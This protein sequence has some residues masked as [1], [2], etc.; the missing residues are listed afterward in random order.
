MA[1]A[2]LIVMYPR[3]KNIGEFESVYHNEHVP[4]A[5]SKLRGKTKIVA[6][7]VVGTPQMTAAF[8]RFAEIHF[9]SMRMLEAC[10]AS[11]EGQEVL[12]HATA[13]SSGG[14]P[15]LLVAEEETFNF[16][17]MTGRPQESLMPGEQGGDA[18]RLVLDIAKALV[19]EL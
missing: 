5:I 9:P 8:H 10:A 6:T 13:I 1:G 11:A 19:D 3:P 4:L 14:P 17:S 15:V 18:R 7:R 16:S 12:A 2:K